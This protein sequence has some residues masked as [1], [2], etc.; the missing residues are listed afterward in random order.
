V[1]LPA[2]YGVAV[3]SLAEG[4]LRAAEPA[5]RLWL[6]ASVPA[7]LP[8]VLLG[9]R[10]LP[11]LVLALIV[12]V[13]ADPRSAAGGVLSSRPAVWLGR[14]GLAGVGIVAMASLVGDV[15]QIL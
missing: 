10:A 9:P 4:W 8:L 5:S 15:A 7:L 12:G 14:A 3:A 2:A 13:V 1:L 6:V 11:F